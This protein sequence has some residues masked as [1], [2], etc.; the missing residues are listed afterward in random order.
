[1]DAFESLP[2]TLLTPAPI[3][4]APK[5]AAGRIPLIAFVDA[6]SERVLHEASVLGAFGR[7]LIMR[8]GIAKAI[9]Y[10]EAQRSPHLLIVDISGVDLPLS[11]MQILADVCE[12]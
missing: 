6:E 12:P 7:S 4:T 5:L 11:Q 8:G 2:N 9:Q 3:E 1:M 10:L